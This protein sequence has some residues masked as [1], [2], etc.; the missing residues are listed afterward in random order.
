MLFEVRKKVNI[1]LKNPLKTPLHLTTC[2]RKGSRDVLH[3]V[4][5]QHRHWTACLLTDSRAC[6][7]PLLQVKRDGMEPL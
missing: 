1:D 3:L 7:E 5:I 4:E 6:V 2:L